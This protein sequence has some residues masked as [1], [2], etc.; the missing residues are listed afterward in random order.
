MC[1]VYTADFMCNRERVFPE[2]SSKNKL[3]YGSRPY[4]TISLGIK[5]LAKHLRSEQPANQKTLVC[6]ST[7]LSYHILSSTSGGTTPLV[8]AD[9]RLVHRTFLGMFNGFISLCSDVEWRSQGNTP[10]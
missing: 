9:Q 3:E 8:Y 1:R 7:K 10:S 6:N 5:T 4:D 2:D